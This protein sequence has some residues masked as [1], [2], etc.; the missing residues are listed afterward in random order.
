MIH[1]IRNRLRK[2]LVAAAVE[3]GHTEEDAKAAVAG[4]L[5]KGECI[6]WD[7]LLEGGFAKLLEA[8]LA[9]LKMFKAGPSAES[10]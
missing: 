9:L 1:P 7:W 8:L 4:V 10:P 6:D 2:K 3:A 5:P